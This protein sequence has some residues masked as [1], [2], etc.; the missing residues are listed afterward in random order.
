MVP[1]HAPPRAIAS[2]RATA[3]GQRLA[4]TIGADALQQRLHLS[5]ARDQRIDLLDLD[6][7]KLAP[8]RLSRGLLCE[9]SYEPLRVA[10][11]A[12]GCP[13]ELHDRQLRDGTRIVVAPPTSSR[14][15][16]QQTEA[17]VVANRGWA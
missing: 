8:T 15:R 16:G 12:T 9:V 10:Q 2:E 5:R 13:G 11:V 4:L 14:G 7:G 1:F 17:L 6:V 3:V